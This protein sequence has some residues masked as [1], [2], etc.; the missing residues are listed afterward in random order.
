MATA[1]SPV[2]PPNPAA[3]RL[4]G[5]RRLSSNGGRRLSGWRPEDVENLFDENDDEQE[6]K[7][8]AEAVEEKKKIQKAKSP[9]RETPG[10]QRRLQLY[11]DCI[12]MTA[13]NVTPPLASTAGC[14]LP[15]PPFLRLGSGLP[16]ARHS[17]AS[18]PAHFPY[19]SHVWLWLHARTRRAPIARPH[20]P[21]T[22]RLRLARAAARQRDQHVGA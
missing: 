18:D 13:E 20:H 11:K 15:P 14:R 6:R 21:P 22:P 8:A 16:H 10:H 7:Q 1:S 2:T 19:S 5:G 3:R 9:F 17:V 12:Q 4:S